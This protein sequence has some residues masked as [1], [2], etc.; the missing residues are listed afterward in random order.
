MKKSS[1]LLKGGLIGAVVGFTVIII[2]ISIEMMFSINYFDRFLEYLGYPL[3]ILY[4]SPCI[5]CGFWATPIMFIIY[6]FLIGVFIKLLLKL[7]EK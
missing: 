3:I 6:G 1:N 2:L 4:N 7:K 5:T